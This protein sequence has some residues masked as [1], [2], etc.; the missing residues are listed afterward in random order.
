MIKSISLNNVR[1]FADELH[2]IPLPPMAL[3]CG[4][5]SAGKSTI[6]K[7][8]LLLRQSIGT[9]EPQCS[10][11]GRLRFAGAQLDVGDYRS[12]V[13]F[14]DISKS[15]QICISIEVNAPISW[16]NLLRRTSD[17]SK[18]PRIDQI[19]PTS[20]NLTKYTLSSEFT[21][22][23]LS[24]SKTSQE[25]RRVCGGLKEAVFTI[26]H[27]DVELIS[28]KVN[29]ARVRN[30]E[31][32]SDSDSDPEYYISIPRI[33]LEKVGYLDFIGYDKADKSPNMKIR[34]VLRGLLPDQLFAK[35]SARMSKKESWSYL[36]MPPHLAN[37]LSDLRRSL[38]EIC[39]LGP[40]RSPAK[41]FYLSHL[42][43]LP[44]IDSTGEYLPA[45][46][47]DHS[48]DLVWTCGFSGGDRPHRV[49]LEIALNIWARYFRTGLFDEATDGNLDIELSVTSDVL[50]EIKIKSVDSI[51][52]HALTDSGFGFSQVLPIIV[53]GLL[54]NPDSTLLIEQPELHLN[55]ALQVRLANFFI[56]MVYSGKQIVLETHSEH[57]VNAVRA[58]CAEDDEQLLHSRCG[59]FYISPTSKSIGV[60][61]LSIRA[62][63][64]VPDWP[65]EFFGEA[66]DL[67]GRIMR[68]QRKHLLK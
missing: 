34:T 19:P 41:R 67:S 55:P 42:D 36:P 47:K 39:Y 2:R 3:F 31:R 9:Q 66:S 59:I 20:D 12:F 13:S 29:R 44:S 30:I 53:Q 45:F 6:L 60:K 58:L 10:T 21:F 25:G 27:R 4:V 48:T 18:S 17:Q 57:I 43:I 22:E 63:G 38:A 64:M 23:G 24:G 14:N 37:A 32:N 7:A 8:I 46:L 40:L 61:E 56:A 33:Y 11:E 5:N 50:V 54:A 26:L 28:W 35:M 1:L 51:R 65:K 68:A 52:S 62:D 15:I 16:V 49:S